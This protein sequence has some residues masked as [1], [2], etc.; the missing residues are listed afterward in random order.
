M[1]KYKIDPADEQ[2]IQEILQC[3]EQPEKPLE[4]KLHTETFRNYEKQ[5]TKPRNDEVKPTAK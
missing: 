5:R 2:C 1:K 3:P 4:A